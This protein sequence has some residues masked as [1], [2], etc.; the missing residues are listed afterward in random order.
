M[1]P[2]NKDRLKAWH[3]SRLHL[4]RH[5]SQKP[6]GIRQDA[7]RIFGTTDEK[8]DCA[9]QTPSLIRASL[10]LPDKTQTL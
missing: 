1:E 6:L 7:L 10:E 3:S 9:S 4:F 5:L 8:S 2:L